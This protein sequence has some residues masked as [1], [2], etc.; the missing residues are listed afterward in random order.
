MAAKRQDYFAAGVELVWEL[1]PV[2]RTVAV[3][4]SPA[5]PTVLGTADTLSGGGVLP[6]FTLP[7]AA[8][9]AELDRQG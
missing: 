6:G 8:L 1:D 3:Y 5:A 4:T 2:A 7:L 9:F